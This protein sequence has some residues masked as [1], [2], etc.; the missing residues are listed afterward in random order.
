MI[1]F[2]RPP[3]NFS[4]K[5]SLEKIGFYYLTFFKPTPSLPLP[6]LREGEGG[7]V[8]NRKMLRKNLFFQLIVKRLRIN[9]KLD[10]IT[11]S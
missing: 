3:K 11:N 10:F 9:G 2:F 5:V 4:L 6:Y 1:S 7:R 8:N